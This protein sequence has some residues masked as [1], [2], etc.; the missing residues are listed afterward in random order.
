[1]NA[2]VSQLLTGKKILNKGLP[3]FYKVTFN[4][5]EPDEGW[6]SLRHF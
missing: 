5:K 1:M 6:Q 4:L 3:T 2:D